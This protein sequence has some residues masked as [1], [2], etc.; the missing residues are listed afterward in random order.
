MARDQGSSTTVKSN[1]KEG[2][3]IFGREL[4]EG[5]EHCRRETGCPLDVL[6][7]QGLAQ[8]RDKIGRCPDQQAAGAAGRP[9]PCRAGDQESHAG[10]SW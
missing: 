7:L 2:A 8:S 3:G 10:S 6:T 4:E 1:E 5:A 9:Q